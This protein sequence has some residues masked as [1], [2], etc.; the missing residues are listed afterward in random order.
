MK[1][2][3]KKKNL[4]LAFNEN[5][6][7]YFIQNGSVEGVLPLRNNFTFFRIYQGDMVGEADILLNNEKRKYCFMTKKGAELL[8][9][10]KKEFKRL[11]LVEYREIGKQ[12]FNQ[13]LKTMKSF[14]INYKKTISHIEKSRDKLDLAKLKSDEIEKKKDENK[15]VL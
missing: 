15:K 6:L 11:I 9:L 10:S 1:V 5:F 3:Y 13:A 12:I 14:K 4:N 7:V 8:T 2:L